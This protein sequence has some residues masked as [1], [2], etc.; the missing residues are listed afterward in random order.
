MIRLRAAAIASLLTAAAAIAAGDGPLNKQLIAADAT[1]VFHIDLE[2]LRASAYGEIMDD[3]ALE[4][5]IPPAQREQI[6]RIRPVLRK[7]MAVTVYGKDDP[8]NAVILLRTTATAEEFFAA[9]QGE[10]PLPP[11]VESTVEVGG[12]T[13]RSWHVEDQTVY[14]FS[15][16]GLPGA[17]LIFLSNDQN[18]LMEAI[19]TARGKRPCLTGSGSTLESDANPRQGAAFFVAASSLDALRRDGRASVMLGNAKSVRMEMGEHAGTVFAAASLRTGSEESARQ[20][21]DMARGLL[22]MGQFSIAQD[23]R[24]APFRGVLE[25]LTVTAD[26]AAASLSLEYDAAKMK[27]AFAAV[28]REARQAEAAEKPASKSKPDAQKP[29]TEPAGR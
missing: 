25:A 24:Q 6:A 10:E 16:A 2:A 11:I 27:E 1:W 20:V 8:D 22:A 26:G 13:L 14:G 28:I 21:A 4:Q 23:P 18:I 15:E 12:N 5:G 3:P 29:K 17:P 7:L 9:M 19:D